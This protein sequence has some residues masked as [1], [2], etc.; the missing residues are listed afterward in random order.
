MLDKEKHMA[1]V[2][3]IMEIS[4]VHNKKFKELLHTNEHYQEM[5]KKRFDIFNAGLV[6]E[7]KINQELR[8]LEL[9]WMT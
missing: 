3:A 7:K 2:D 1:F 5:I 6:R 4:I 8:Y 9:D